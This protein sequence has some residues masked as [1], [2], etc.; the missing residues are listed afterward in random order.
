MEE[1]KPCQHKYHS[2]H[3]ECMECFLCGYKPPQLF[4]PLHA[5]LVALDI[6]WPP[7]IEQGTIV[8]GLSNGRECD[9]YIEGFNRCLRQCKKAVSKSKQPLTLPSRER[10][11]IILIKWRKRWGMEPLPKEKTDDLIDAMIDELKKI[12]QFP[13]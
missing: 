1:I 2:V 4:E 9:A 12:N 3:S 7:T 10:I 5:P 8:A 11:E 6:E 13:Q